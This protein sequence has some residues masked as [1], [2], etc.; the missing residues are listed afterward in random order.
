MR[1]ATGFYSGP[2]FLINVN[3]LHLTSNLNTKLFADDTGLFYHDKSLTELQKIIN[4]QIK[5]DDPWFKSNKLTLNYSKTN[6]MAIN[7]KKDSATV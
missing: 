4:E 1:S 5:K 6:F 2:A 3:D 7:D